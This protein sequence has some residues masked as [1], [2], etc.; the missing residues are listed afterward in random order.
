MLILLPYSTMVMAILRIVTLSRINYNDFEYTG[1]APLIY[2]ILEPAIGI[3]VA[4]VPLMQPLFKG[5]WI[6]NKLSSQGSSKPKRSNEKS[7]NFKRLDN[8]HALKVLKP[9]SVSVVTRG[10]QSSDI[11][12]DD[13]HEYVGNT[14]DETMGNHITIKREFMTERV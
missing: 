5:T 14:H 11:E 2:S 6:G 8:E 9:N 10:D 4:C 1:S 7:R 13:L 3:S 12:N